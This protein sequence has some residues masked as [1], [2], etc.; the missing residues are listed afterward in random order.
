MSDFFKI[1][2]ENILSLEMH[3]YSLFIFPPWISKIMR[4]KKKK[5]ENEALELLTKFLWV[6]TNMI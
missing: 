5:K 3:P 2:L 4:Q 6:L 1:F